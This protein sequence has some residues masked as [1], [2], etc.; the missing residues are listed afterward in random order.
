MIPVAYEICS[1]IFMLICTITGPI[2]SGND[3]I[4][5]RYLLSSTQGHAL[6]LVS[7]RQTQATGFLQC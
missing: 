2:R 6:S 4:T 7:F 5:I 1:D 3:M